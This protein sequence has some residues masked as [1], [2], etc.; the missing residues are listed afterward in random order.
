MDHKELPRDEQYWTPEELQTWIMKV[1]YHCQGH[2][3]KCR[4]PWCD[5]GDHLL[6]M[7]EA[8]PD[9]TH[10]HHCKERCYHVA[11]G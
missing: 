9:L 5:A 6:I 2:K 1:A 11:R 10:G 3:P 7:L 4:C 8:R